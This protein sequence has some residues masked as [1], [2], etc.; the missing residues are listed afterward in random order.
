MGKGGNG[1]EKVRV[2]GELQNMGRRPGSQW[3][4]PL[5]GP[6]CYCGEVVSVSPRGLRSVLSGGPAREI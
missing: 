3:I 4:R 6:Q 2:T 1:E 5:R